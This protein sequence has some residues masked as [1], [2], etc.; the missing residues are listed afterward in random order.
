M[1]TVVQDEQSKERQSVMSVHL[2]THRSNHKDVKNKDSDTTD[3]YAG[4]TI[5]EMMVLHKGPSR[6]N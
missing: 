6:D 5:E 1:S 2:G 4:R 3:S